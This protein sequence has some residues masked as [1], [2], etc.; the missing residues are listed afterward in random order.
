MRGNISKHGCSALCIRD[1]DVGLR[2]SYLI[3]EGNLFLQ[4]CHFL[5]HRSRVVHVLLH[6]IQFTAF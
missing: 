4:V 5:Q 1:K 3:D 2:S 6:H